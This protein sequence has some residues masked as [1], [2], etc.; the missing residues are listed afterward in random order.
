MFHPNMILQ[1]KNMWDRFQMNHPKFPRFLQVVGAE[2]MQE[3]TIIEISVTKPDGENITSNLRL[4]ETDMEMIAALREL[5][6]QS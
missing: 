4:N 1:I 5:S 2:C 6:R 3:G